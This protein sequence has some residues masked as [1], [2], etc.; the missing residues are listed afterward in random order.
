[1]RRMINRR[2]WLDLAAATKN[3]TS[4]DGVRNYQARNYMRG[5]NPSLRS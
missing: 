5:F 1:M 4:W 3:T 2:Y